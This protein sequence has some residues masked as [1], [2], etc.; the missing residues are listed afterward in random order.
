MRSIGCHVGT[1]NGA[2]YKSFAFRDV[3]M[4]LG[5]KLINTKAYAPKTNGK[6]ERFVQ[7]SLR[8][9]AD[10]QAYPTSDHRASELPRRLP[11]YN[12]HRHHGP[13]KRQTPISPLDL[14]E[15]CLL[16]IHI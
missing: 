12:R 11:Q 16:S 1:D 14:P 6:A 2:C 7:T 5:L 4:A 13:I 10:A 8:E 15:E 9:W 3:C